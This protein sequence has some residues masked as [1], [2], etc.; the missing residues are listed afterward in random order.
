MYKY[1]FTVSQS[2]L[3]QTPCAPQESLINKLVWTNYYF[4]RIHYVLYSKPWP[5]H[6]ITKYSIALNP[7]MQWHSCTQCASWRTSNTSPLSLI[8]DQHLSWLLVG[9]PRESL[10]W[11]FKNSGLPSVSIKSYP[12]YPVNHSTT[13]QTRI[14]PWLEV[15]ARVRMSL[16]WPRGSRLLF[17]HHHIFFQIPTTWDLQGV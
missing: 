3:P 4:P 9:V 8:Q 17:I 14:L 5:M 6:M 15:L 11:S 7:S 12:Y 1:L 13:R 2:L 10:S 16:A